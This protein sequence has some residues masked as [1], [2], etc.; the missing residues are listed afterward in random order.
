MIT[1]MNDIVTIYGQ[2]LIPKH[3]RF[4]LFWESMNFTVNF[5]YEFYFMTIEINYIVKYWLLSPEFQ[6]RNLPHS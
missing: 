1:K 3:V 5:N 6:S 2:Y 4:S